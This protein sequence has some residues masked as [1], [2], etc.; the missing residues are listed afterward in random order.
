[1]SM[2]MLISITSIRGLAGASSRAEAFGSRSN[3]PLRPGSVAA[4]R[5]EGT[6]RAGPL[7][8]YRR[9]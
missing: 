2:R 6:L 7:R 8:S 9:P 3:H 4:T 5:A 1:M